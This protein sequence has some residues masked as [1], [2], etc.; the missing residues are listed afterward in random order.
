MCEQ[1]WVSTL[2]FVEFWLL[3]TSGIDLRM[4]SLMLESRDWRALAEMGGLCRCCV[5]LVA[6]D[7]ECYFDGAFILL[8]VAAITV[9]WVLAN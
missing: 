3:C 5:L 9:V 7:V 2:S 8:E 4:D 1:E 6:I